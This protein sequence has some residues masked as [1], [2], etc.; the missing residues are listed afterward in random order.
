MRLF[1]AHV[2]EL[3]LDAP[4]SALHKSTRNPKIDD[5]NLAL[6]RNEH[7]GRTDVSMDNAQRMPFRIHRAVGI[8]QSPQNL[9][10]D[11]KGNGNG[12]FFRA[13]AS[14]KN[15][16]VCAFDKLHCQIIFAPNLAHIENL[17]DVGMGQGNKGSPLVEKTFH[18]RCIRS[19]LPANFFDDTTLF[20][21]GHTEEPRP[22]DLPHAS[23]S[24]QPK[25]RIA[26]KM[27]Y[28]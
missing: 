27:L 7:I 14:Q 16:E 5:L 1:R 17:D 21:S 9:H 6:S 22:I 13:N 23:A 11:G 8:T 4:L 28:L 26:A 3:S 20:K 15:P 2:G 25:K 18:K 24:H 12:N 19:K 10:G